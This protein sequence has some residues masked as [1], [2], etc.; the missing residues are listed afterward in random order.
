MRV[1]ILHMLTTDDV[2]LQWPGVQLKM[3]DPRALAVLGTPNGNGIA[4]FLGQHK[5][6]LG[7]KI[8][9]AVNVFR[10]RPVNESQQWC[11]YFHVVDKPDS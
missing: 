1:S 9:D 5:G 7:H 3:D 2:A 6:E 11:L 4:W 8:I 10:C